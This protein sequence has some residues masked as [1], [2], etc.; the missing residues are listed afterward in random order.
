MTTAKTSL[1]EGTVVIA[2]MRSYAAWPAEIKS[3]RKTCVEVHFF[4]DDS[5]GTV[6]YENVGLFQDNVELI[7]SNLQKSIAGYSKAVRCTE[8]FLNV[9]SHLSIMNQI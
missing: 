8:I 6:P 7:R 9:P 4:G 5:T 3:L 1:T 2:K